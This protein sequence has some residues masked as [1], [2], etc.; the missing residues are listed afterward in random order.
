MKKY[1]APFAA[2]ILGAIVVNAGLFYALQTKPAWLT[3]FVN[4][5]NVTIGSATLASASTTVQ[6]LVAPGTSI[7]D[8][9]AKAN[10]AVVSITITKDVPTYKQTYINPF[11][12]FGGM[13]MNI[14]VP[15]LQQDGTQSQEVGGGSG[16]LISSDGY[17]VTN[18]HVVSDSTAT[19]TVYTTDGTSYPAKVIATDSTLDIAL[20]KIDA[21]NLPYL[22]FADSDKIELG[23][24]VVAIG[25][26]LDQF[27]NTVSVG[28]VSGLSRT[29]AAGDTYG[30]SEELDGIIQTDA[31]INPGNSGGPLLDVNGNVVGV[32]V[33]MAGNSQNIGFSLPA[34]SIKDAI[35]SMK[36][37][38]KVVRAFLGV[39]YIPVD[40]SLQQKNSLS[41]D[42]GALV[43]RGQNA[44]ELAVTPGSPADKAG[45]VEN[46]IILEVNGTK[47]D[48]SHSL[49]YLIRQHKIGET[50][51]LH[52]QHKGKEEDVSVTL[53]AMPT[54]T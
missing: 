37:T 8:M 49:G 36:T 52:I 40:K 53:E 43:A 51:T 47:I 2:G 48:D 4:L 44:D 7:P 15:Q 31:A 42:Y 16:F 30:N 11:Q 22:S 20:V 29:I 41:V 14:Q 23:D 5:P 18:N 24:T 45:I 6:P 28:V 21:T 1:L 46:D 10:P 50:I 54:S 12:G 13:G 25:N 3:K 32:N 33:A 38:G 19:Y 27:R 39:R 26:A 35:E 34:N 17:I 9:V